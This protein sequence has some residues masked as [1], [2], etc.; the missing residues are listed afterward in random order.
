MGI[1]CSFSESIL[2]GSY[3][4]TLYRNL[5]NDSILETHEQN[6]DRLVKIETA[7]L[8]NMVAC[9]FVNCVTNLVGAKNNK[10][11]KCKCMGR[12]GYISSLSIAE[13]VWQALKVIR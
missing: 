6:F 3:L 9:K 10:I 13:H 4:K 8:V 12:H 1:L 11:H 5:V 7:L 2:F